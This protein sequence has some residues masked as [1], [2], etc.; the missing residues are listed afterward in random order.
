MQEKW[1]GAN[2]YGT[3]NAPIANLVAVN[4]VFT[5]I[6][7]HSWLPSCGAR[8]RHR[9]LRAEP[10]LFRPLRQP[11]LPASATGGG[12][13][14]CPRLRR[15]GS[16]PTSTKIRQTPDWVSVLFGGEGGTRTL[17]PV[18]RPIP[19]A[20]VPLHQLEYFSIF[21]KSGRWCVSDF[22]YKIVNLAERVGFEPTVRCRTTVFKTVPL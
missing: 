18:S 8:K 9:A 3:M 13:K 17:A 4:A 11:L 2:T 16:I 21:P 12:R 10:R 19:L 22:C 14:R 7:S 20:G 1:M 15:S 5:G 6:R